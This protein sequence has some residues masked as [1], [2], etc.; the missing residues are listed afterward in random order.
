[1]AAP[2]RGVA[3]ARHGLRVSRARRAGRVSVTLPVVSLGERGILFMNHDQF[4]SRAGAA[5]TQS[6]IRRMGGVAA[7]GRDIISFAPGY[8]APDTFAWDDFRGIAAELLGS[9]DPSVLQY[10]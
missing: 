3:A 10:G 1:A 6:A 8:P 2:A 4:L 5:M 9:R 7:A